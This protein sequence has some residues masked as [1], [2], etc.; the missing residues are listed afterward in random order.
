MNFGSNLKGILSAT[1]LKMYNLADALGYDKSYIS[2]WV[3][4]AKLPPAKDID[5]LIDHIAGFVVGECTDRTKRHAAVKL[6]FVAED[7]A[8]LSDEQF[9]KKIVELLKESYWTDRYSSEPFQQRT[10]QLI[11]AAPVT[12]VGKQRR[13]TPP[14][15]CFLSTQPLNSALEFQSVRDVLSCLDPD[16]TRLKIT[17]LIDSSLFSRHIDIYWRH[18]CNLLS[19]GGNVDVD[20]YEFNQS[21]IT[22]LPDRLLIVK[23][24]FVEQSIHLPFSNKSVAVKIDVPSVV[25]LYYDD[26]RKFTHRHQPMLESSTING[27]LYYYKFSR[28]TR[29]RYLLSS[30]FPMYMSVGLYDELLNKYG[31]PAHREELTRRRYLKEFDTA[32]SAIIYET[33]LL[34]YMGTGKISAFD[35]FEGETL[36]RQERRRHL[37][38]LINELEDGSRLEIKILS[39]KNPILN[40]SDISVS[41]FMNDSSAYYSDIRKKKDGVRYFT[42]KDSRRN[43]S[44]L[45]DHMDGLSD[46]YMVTGEKV[47]DYIF[48]GMRNI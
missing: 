22:T 25:D 36:T 7:G 11:P 4:G 44:T 1:N 5:A 33:A 42:S 48:D 12:T 41:F 21:H 34:R 45:L 13:K 26:A 17:A 35:A 24:S 46:E 30:M 14:V 43:L 8:P 47:I 38:E 27:N 3:N 40:Y 6:N 18:I 15:E 10:P 16:N 37:Q 2:K 29:K 39:D 9:T 23:D 32:K 28:E 20:L 19:L 31:E